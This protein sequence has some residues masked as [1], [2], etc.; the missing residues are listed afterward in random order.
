M[1]VASTKK[2]ITCFKKYKIYFGLVLLT[3]VFG[4]WYPFSFYPMYNNFPNW[5]YT[6]Y[7][8]DEHG[9]NLKQYMN[10]YHS[11]LSHLYYSA[12]EK[13]EISYGYAMETKEQLHVV[14]QIMIQQV[15]EWE[16]IKKTTIDEIRLYRIHN[17]IKKRK[18]I[19][20]TVLIFKRDAN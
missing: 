11:S 3:F 1:K 13:Q 7:V 15:L 9:N 17:Y 4:E 20:D 16:K 2:L 8:E 12:C 10:A 5:S 18:I 19:S 6:F 14:G